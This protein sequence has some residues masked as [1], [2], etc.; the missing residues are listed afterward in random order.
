MGRIAHRP[1]QRFPEATGGRARTRF[2]AGRAR[3]CN[4]RAGR[5]WIETPW[6]R[7]P[8][9][10]R[11]RR[12]H[13]AAGVCVRT[14]LASSARIAR[15]GRVSSR[16]LKTSPS[17]ADS[18]AVPLVVGIAEVLHLQALMLVKR[19]EQETELILEIVQ[20]GDR[21][22]REVGR[23]KNESL[24]HITAAP[25]M[26]EHNQIAAEKPLGIG[27][28]IG[29]TR[30]ELCCRRLQSS[31]HLRDAVQVIQRVDELTAYFGSVRAMVIRRCGPSAFHVRAGGAT[32][33][34]CASWRAGRLR[35]P[36][37]DRASLAT[38]FQWR[39]VRWHS[40]TF[41]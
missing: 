19:R 4:N 39:C 7:S 10:A 6:A 33:A 23:F 24:R 37:I 29:Q 34:V 16:H 18:A 30:W 14:S 25:E 27:S 13:A 26:I 22:V 41:L 11:C 31:S 9:S 5:Q 1:N 17:P 38:D 2:R 21:A 20:V 12:R 32:E 35:R 8:A 40:L 3:C 15:C 28:G 36:S